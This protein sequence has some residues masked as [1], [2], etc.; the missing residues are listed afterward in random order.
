MILKKLTQLRHG[1]KKTTL[2]RPGPVLKIS[3]DYN[4]KIK[5]ANKIKNKYQKK[6]IG[7]KNKNN[8]TS[9]D[10]LKTAGYLDTKDQDKI[11]YIFVPPKKETTNKI[12]ED[13][14]LFIR[15][16]IDL[17]DFKK[18]NLSSKIRKD[19]TKK[20]IFY[21]EKKQE[22]V[23]EDSTET[24]KILEDIA[25][26][27]PGKNAQLAAKKISEKHKKIREA[28]AR[29]RKYKIPGEIVRI[30]EV[31]TPLGKSK[32]SSFCRKNS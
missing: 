2:T 31:E 22:E 21:K 6:N 11:N 8:K 29:K 4:R 18:E 5:V 14:C 1:I 19:K 12:P 23:P 3:K 32:S 25:N 15:I 20:P 17:A 7:Q 9:A 26:L 13:A 30:E 28:N 24:I 27:E 16:E 10:C